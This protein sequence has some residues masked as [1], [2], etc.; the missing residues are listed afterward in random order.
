MLKKK[1]TKVS[2]QRGSFTHGWGHKKKH[3]GAGSRGGVGLAGTGARGDQKKQTILKEK[4]KD[5][6]G[7]KGFKKKNVRTYLTITRRD[8]ENNLENMLKRKLIVEE[9]GKYVLNFKKPVKIL[10]KPKKNSREF[11][12]KKP[13]PNKN[14]KVNKKD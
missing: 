6:F 7:K 2:R 11:L 4:G 12:V 8:L 14:K 9:N 1:R 3:R 5:Y 10:G 13:F